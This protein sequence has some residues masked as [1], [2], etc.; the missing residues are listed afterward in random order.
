MNKFFVILLLFSVFFISG[1]SAAI[2]F[3]GKVSINELSSTWVVDDE[4]DGDFKSIQKAIKRANSGDTIEVY[5]GI[6]NEA[7]KIDKKL[8]LKGVNYEF[9]EGEDSGIPI[10]NGLCKKNVL[11]IKADGCSLTGFKIINSKMKYYMGHGINVL[12]DNCVISGNIVEKNFIGIG[13]VGRKNCIVTNNTVLYNVF[14]INFGN[15]LYCT[16]S[17]NSFLNSGLIISSTANNI[18]TNIVRNNTINKKPYHMYV[19]LNDTHISNSDA[20][21]VALIDCHNLTIENLNISNTT[22]GLMVQYCSGITICNSTFTNIHRGGISLHGD[23]CEIYGNT[24]EN[25]S[26]GCYIEGGNNFHLH[27][28]NFIQV[29]KHDQPALSWIKKHQSFME[30]TNIKYNQNYW[31]DWIGLKIPLLQ[32]IPKIIPGFRT[33][34]HKWLNIFPIFQFDLNPALEPY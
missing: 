31:D 3:N 4:G 27:H 22:I 23:E 10:L 25:C 32:R 29:F 12:S 9:G 28:N 17:N 30:S 26:Y 21:Q 15:S 24:F 18:L 5:S 19:Q 8:V 6:Y 33:F 13:M 16:L 11:V 14:G 34:T 7:I 1:F 20:G 2:T